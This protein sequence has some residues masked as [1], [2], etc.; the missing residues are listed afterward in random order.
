MKPVRK[1]CY[2]IFKKEIMYRF[3]F[4]SE[5]KNKVKLMRGTVKRLAGDGPTPFS[6][7]G[8]PPP[9][10][11]HP[12]NGHPNP[13]LN[14]LPIIPIIWDIDSDRME[15]FAAL[16]LS[17]ETILTRY[18]NVPII[19]S[20]FKSSESMFNYLNPTI[21]SMLDKQFL[22]SQTNKEKEEEDI[23]KAFQSPVD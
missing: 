21:N 15:Y 2:V 12:L 18:H 3:E 4:L 19:C 22:S 20:T 6:I 16:P 7:N 1:S 9:P 23:K 13:S 10:T 14:C 17:E 5:S 8:D 11:R